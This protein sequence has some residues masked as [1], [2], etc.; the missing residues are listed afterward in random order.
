MRT[1]LDPLGAAIAR[2]VPAVL[3][4]A[5]NDELAI[6]KSSVYDILMD[7]GCKNVGETA[8]RN[9]VTST[10]RAIC[11][12]TAITR[13]FDIDIKQIGMERTGAPEDSPMSLFVT[14]MSEGELASLQGYIQSTM[15]DEKI[16]ALMTND[17]MAAIEA[18]ELAKAPG[19]R[20]P[21][22]TKD[23]ARMA[24]QVVA[25]PVQSWLPVP[26]EENPNDGLYVVVS[27]AV[28]IDT[29]SAEVDD[30]GEICCW[31][32]EEPVI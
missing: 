4:A 17:E 13:Q 16:A 27:M 21:G 22:W 7:G 10:V 2:D 24:D 9:S 31:T 14:S 19:I 18:K 11:K 5:S 32:Y 29:L 12:A 8:A 25:H 3:G 6:L 28:K 23:I 1:A 20:D 30:N 15:D 26:T